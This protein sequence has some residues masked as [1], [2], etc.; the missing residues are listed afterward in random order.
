M[1]P[2]F[3]RFVHPIAHFSSNHFEAP[4][5]GSTSQQAIQLSLP[6]PRGTDHV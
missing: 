2:P 6:S 5:D 1:Q 3:S 4:T